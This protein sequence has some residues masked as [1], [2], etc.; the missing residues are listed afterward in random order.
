LFLLFQQAR[1]AEVEKDDKKK[2]ATASIPP[3]SSSS[4]VRSTSPSLVP[5]L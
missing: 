4:K 3:S 2:V 1:L 5:S